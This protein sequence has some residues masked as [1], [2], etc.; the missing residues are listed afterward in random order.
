MR[1][2]LGEDARSAITRILDGDK[3][4]A[5]IRREVAIWQKQLVRI[6]EESWCRIARAFE[7]SCG[8]KGPLS[9]G[10]GTYVAEHTRLLPGQ[11]RNAL[12]GLPAAQRPDWI[13]SMLKS[14]WTGQLLDFSTWAAAMEAPIHL[15]PITAGEGEGEGTDRERTPVAMGTEEFIRLLVER[16]KQNPREAIAILLS[17]DTALALRAAEYFGGDVAEKNGLRAEAE[18]VMGGLA[19]RLYETDR[20][21]L[22]T[23]VEAI[24]M[25][26]QA[27]Q[28]RHLANEHDWDTR[29]RSIEA[30]GEWLRD[31]LTARQIGDMTEDAR[32]RL[33]SIG[34]YD[35]M[36]DT[37]AWLSGIRVVALWTQHVGGGAI[38]EI[39][40][41]GEIFPELPDEDDEDVRRKA[42]D[43]LLAALATYVRIPE[44]EKD[45]VWWK[46]GAGTEWSERTTE[47]LERLEAELPEWTPNAEDV[48]SI[49]ESQEVARSTWRF[50]YHELLPRMGERAV[51]RAPENRERDNGGERCKEKVDVET[52]TTRSPRSR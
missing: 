33:R 31:R 39:I 43:L 30:F 35:G 11:I 2:E 21:R 38:G 42:A 17:A 47:T 24:A 23:Y 4:L 52:N 12:N 13:V 1:Q 6:Q 7:R 48:V 36:A 27:P 9:K 14:G 22:P 5:R 28:S 32:D 49:L 8:M 51:P 25:A 50:A 3:R 45:L 44:M 37:S 26:L 41:H 19:A 20:E 10:E 18:A 15:A 46:E 29:G 34:E 16:A 40:Q